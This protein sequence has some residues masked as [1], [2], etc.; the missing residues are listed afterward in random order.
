MFSI[1]LKKFFKKTFF[2]IELFYII[3]YILYLFFCLY[4]FLY[5]KSNAQRNFFYLEACKTNWCKRQKNRKS[6]NHSNI[7]IVLAVTSFSLL[8]LYFKKLKNTSSLS[9]ILNFSTIGVIEIKSALYS[10]KHI[11]KTGYRV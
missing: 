1:P 3:F 4:V 8:G 5:E 10:Q 9:K 11:N 2:D 7:S 6:Y